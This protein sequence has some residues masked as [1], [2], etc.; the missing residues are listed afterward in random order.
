MKKVIMVLLCVV[1][2]LLGMH[3]S[4]VGC[5]NYVWNYKETLCDTSISPDGSYELI[6]M[7][8]GEPK[9]PF[10]SAPG[11]LILKE[12]EY[13]VSQA[14]FEIANDGGQ[15]NSS[16]WTVLWTETYVEVILAGEEQEDEQFLFYF[17]GSIE[18][19][20]LRENA[21]TE[22]AQT[23]PEIITLDIAVL[24]NRENELVFNISI[25]DY[26]DCYNQ[27][28]MIDQG[29]SYLLPSVRW[30]SYPYDS[31]I[32]S[33]HKTYLYYFTEDERVYTLPTITVYVPSNGDYIQEISVNFDEHSYSESGFEQYKE[34]CFYTVKVFFPDLSD[35]Q[36]LHL[37]TEIITL[38]NQNVF[39]SD[40]WYSSDSVPCAL[41]YKD[42]VG[43]YPYFAI[44]DWEHFCIIP[45]TDEIIAEFEQK[46]VEINEIK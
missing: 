19:Q 43:I 3:L 16:C 24:E 17:D 36:I 5:V 6:L 32:H 25:D 12:G 15:I 18:R 1:I 8:V 42:G 46:G 40:E 14:D 9:F 11:R 41:Y 29:R 21:I 23:K 31:A 20:Y 28:F 22:T 38:G 45:V 44:G 7:A 10:G 35:E 2:L 30:Q 34:M 26:I 27:F 13:Q 33:E 37:C 4:L 39:S